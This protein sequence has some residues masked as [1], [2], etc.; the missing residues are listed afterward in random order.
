[1]QN[2][3][4]S[5]CSTFFSTLWVVVITL[6][7]TGCQGKGVANDLNQREANEV[8]S[9]LADAG[10][11][12]DIARERGGRGKYSVEV[13][14]SDFTR[15][16]QVLHERGLPAERQP[17]FTELVSSGGIL[18]ASREAEALKLDRAI[19]GQVEDL[20][21]SHPAVS[22]VSVFASIQGVTA[23]NEPT[24]SI[25]IARRQNSAL[26]VEDVREIASRAVMNVR[27]EKIGITI[28]QEPDAGSRAGNGAAGTAAGNK[29]ALAPFLG[30]WRVPVSDYNGLALTLVGVLCIVGLAAGLMG[31]FL[32]QYK[33]VKEGEDLMSLDS[34][35][36]TK[37]PRL[38]RVRP[39]SESEDDE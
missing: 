39:D 22:R 16:V 31:Y 8:V 4:Q 17:S 30:V 29:E 10:I 33:V 7:L 35:P 24:I 32:G 34:S 20:L 3:Q 21:K 5:N 15:A 37:T 6:A 25:T 1:M 26:S 28:W 11:T 14:A 36:S 27:P 38:D 2:R 23:P 19:A 13:P 12:S 9:V 18:P